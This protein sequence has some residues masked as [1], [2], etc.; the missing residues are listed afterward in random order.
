MGSLAPNMLLGLLI[1]LV[2]I[3]VLK[4]FSPYLIRYKL[5]DSSE[6]TE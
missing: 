6:D 3:V 5:K 2:Y 1:Y 4:A